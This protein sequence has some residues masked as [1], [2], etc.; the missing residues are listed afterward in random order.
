MWLAAFF[1]LAR[2]KKCPCG[3]SPRAGSRV[4]R[5]AKSRA[6]CSKTVWEIFLPPSRSLV[7]AALRRVDGPGGR[8]K[9]GFSSRRE[10]RWPKRTELAL[11]FPK[12]QRSRALSSIPGPTIVLPPLR[13]LVRSPLWRVDR[14][15]GPEKI[16]FASRRAR[17]GGEKWT[18][19]EGLPLLAHQGRKTGQ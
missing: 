4:A 14:P 16:K 5:E 17:R 3:P 6:V 12:M 10:R 1:E 13:R 9:S 19:A 15:V 11:R 7:R 18:I 8:G 2:Q